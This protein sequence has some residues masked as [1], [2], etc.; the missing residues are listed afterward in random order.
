[1]SRT[2][3]A[4]VIAAAS[5]TA[6]GSFAANYGPENQTTGT[7]RVSAAGGGVALTVLEPAAQPAP[8]AGERFAT[9]RVVLTTPSEVVLHTAK[10]MRDFAVSPQTEET[11]VPVEGERVTVGYVPEAG[12][13]Q[14]AAVEP[15]PAASEAPARVAEVMP[16]PA[17]G[18]QEQDAMSAGTHADSTPATTTAPAVSTAVAKDTHRMTRLPKTAS[19]RPLI[20]LA[21][22]LAVAAAGTLRVALRA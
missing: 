1:M 8:L 7:S 4:A 16:A 15:A 5:V 17:A 3:V 14:F 12:S 2:F 13:V 9:G 21:G 18:S 11:A 22:V 10:G 20:L 6:V 19:D